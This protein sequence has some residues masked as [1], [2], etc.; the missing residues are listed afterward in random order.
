[1]VS[2]GF[3]DFEITWRGDVFSGAVQSSSAAKN[4]RHQ[5]PSAKGKLRS[6]IG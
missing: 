5:F 2:A 4:L 1:V 6:G 3:I